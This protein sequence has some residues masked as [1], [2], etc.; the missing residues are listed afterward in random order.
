MSTTPSGSAALQVTIDV[1]GMDCAS[2]VA[3]V[4]K[5]AR[6]VSGVQQCQVNLALGRAMVA[7]DPQQTSAAVIADA[8]N[9]A[10]YAASLDRGASPA[11]AE[12]DRLRRHHAEA[13]SWMRRAV[14][15]VALW[16][17]IELA[18]WTAMLAGL[19]AW[20]RPL[21]WASLAAGTIA[22]LYI[23]WG[24]YAGAI[25]GLR[26]RAANM[27]CLIA[28]GASV[29][30]GYSLVAFV[31]ALLGW[32]PQPD[33]L[34]FMESA[35]LLALISLGHY[36]ESR[37]RDAAGSAIHGLLQLAPS[38]ALRQ[39]DGNGDFVEV[40]VS[41]LLTGDRVLVRPGDRV[42]IDGVVVEGRSSVDESMLTG[43]PL[44][45]TR[46]IDDE[47]IGGTINHDGRLIVRAT[48]VGAETALSQIVQLVE[49]AQSSKTPVQKLADR[50]AGIFV[51]AVLGIA[52]VTALGWF[53]FGFAHYGN[54]AQTWA[55][56]A[57]AVCSVLIIACPC[58]L[59]LAVPAAV[60]VGMGRGAGRGILIR[61]IDALQH[62]E[63]IQ[64][65][66]LDKTGTIT[67]GKPT[68]QRIITIGDTSEMD[69][70]RYAAA[71]ELYSAHPLARSIVQAAK[72]R[73]L[74]IPEPDGFTTEA[75][76]G[77][78]ATLGDK[79]LL[80]GSEVLLRNHGKLTAGY[81]AE[82]AG[83]TLVHVAW[84]HAD[85]RVERFGLLVIADRLKEDSIEAVAE[86][87]AM[88]LS[89]VLLT[90]DNRA[91]A[92]TIARKVG[93][94]QFH[95]DVRPDQKADVIRKLQESGRVVAM[96]GDGINDAPALA[97]ADL[98]IALG[99]GSDIAK[100]TGQ[101]VLV[102]PSLKG[103]AMAIRLSRATMTKIRQNL[104]LAFIYN[105]LAIPLAAFGVLNPLI[106]AGAMAL[107]DVS[108]IGNALLLR[109]TRIEQ[110]ASA[111]KQAER[112]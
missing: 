40:P 58:A 87:H 6:N 57:N 71:A 55:N 78:I 64:L 75:G 28:M 24:F 43:E 41:Q 46:S 14:V 67:T 102:S 97:Q 65:V 88:G 34:Y 99:S 36:L 49:T 83:N 52:L 107:S 16:L 7:F 2:C 60:M 10:G 62:A 22:I 81:P 90:G 100:E 72:A 5:A 39:G 68:V 105:V 108:V 51:P 73:Q 20:H 33:S 98:G 84:K 104:F 21:E 37:A 42:P 112:Q 13:A 19:H 93:I 11:Q 76:L 26:A 8:I 109:R 91:A 96:V 12:E 63:K 77:V 15:G 69:V 106:A 95:A 101:I 82:E 1:E 50:I 94:D 80:V 110:I 111:P 48:R 35:G 59:G 103:I 89:V 29:A 44:P 4:E 70:L 54:S 23:G 31:G 32:W 86:L 27:D 38:V 17:P 53:I 79:T 30:Y 45:V 25:K 18:H 56:V 92:A 74:E 85:G 47:V 9:R 3:H 66:V 61:D